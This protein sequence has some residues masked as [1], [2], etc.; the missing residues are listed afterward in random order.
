MIVVI[1][2]YDSFVFNLVRYLKESTQ[3]EI[4][5][6]R[7]DKV[8]Y[9]IL[10]NCKA[11]LLSPGPGIPNEAGDLIPI[12]KKYAES[13]KILGIC[14][15]HQAIG[16]VFGGILEQCAQP[17]HGKSSLAFHLNND[18]IFNEIPQEFEVGRYH[19]WRI[20]NILPENLIA[21]C[22]TQDNELMAMKHK[23]LDIKGIQ[24]HPESILTPYGR[25]MIQ[26]WILDLQL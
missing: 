25:K 14:L 13:K 9:A 23:T 15:G 7:N 2:N 12:I 19:S 10:D 18:S 1:D 11:I 26:N 4:Q 24:F 6:M 21:T 16:E 3:T 17:I 8:D 5:V 22:F 20:G